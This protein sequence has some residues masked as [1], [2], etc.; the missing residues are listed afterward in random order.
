MPSEDRS[1]LPPRY[2]ALLL[3][4]ISG[5]G[6]YQALA[7]RTNADVAWYLYA[8]ARIL[9]GA[10]LGADIIEVNAPLIIVLS[11]GIEG[12]ARLIGISAI[13]LLPWLITA[14]SCTSI[15]V[16]A[17]LARPWNANVRQWFL[18]GLAFVLL[19][20]VGGMMGQREHLLVILVMPYV[21]LLVREADGR[22]MR[23]SAA[24]VV[25][26]VAAVGFGLKPFFLPAWVAL[27]AYMVVRRGVRALCRAQFVAMLAAFVLYA[28]GILVWTPDYL[29]FAAESLSL[30]RAYQP[31]GD[32]PVILSSSFGFVLLAVAFACFSGRSVARSL[33]DAGAILG[34]ML[35]FAVFLQ[36]KGWHY[37]WYP[38][39]ALAT[40]LFAVAAGALAARSRFITAAGAQGIAAFAVILLTM[41]TYVFWTVAA[42]E[43]LEIDALVRRHADGAAILAL[44]SHL[45]V[46][47]P[48]VNETK[49]R[50][51]SRYPT[52]WQL[53]AFCNESTAACRSKERVFL[54]AVWVDLVSALPALLIVDSVPPTPSLAG[55]DY[56][57]Y[58]RRDSRMATVLSDY[59]FLKR[60]GRYRVFLRS[61]L[62]CGDSPT[63]P[64]VTAPEHR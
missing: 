44:S 48:L 45:H 25:G 5:W 52:M 4:A 33:I 36:G 6:L 21:C 51:A 38:A 23:P 39:V 42:P 24:A 40:I 27:E 10:R 31:Y 54:D 19:I 13:T 17:W 47:F 34:I 32:V 53:P 16:C 43:Q 8:G 7:I 60:I 9:D 11:M 28:L 1:L 62:E 30:Y 64:L 49:V 14:L 61:D 22:P 15:G 12:L 50:W 57:D 59:R 46:G 56:L 37:Q 63:Q 20:D 55:F 29:V 58:F 35:S 26:I 2:V 3:A 18:V 41:R